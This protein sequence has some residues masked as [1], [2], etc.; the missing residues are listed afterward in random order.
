MSDETVSHATIASSSTP[1]FY[2]TI[3]TSQ[4]PALLSGFNGGC[5]Q[6][7]GVAD[8]EA[9][10]RKMCAAFGRKW[11]MMYESLDDVHVLDRHI[12]AILP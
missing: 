12:V 6:I 10:S 2:A 7:L 9:A 1:P 5:V 11:S 3:T 8:R 4:Y